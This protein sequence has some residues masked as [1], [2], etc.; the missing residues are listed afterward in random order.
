MAGRSADGAVLG[1]DLS[2]FKEVTFEYGQVHASGGLLKKALP[3][4]TK[5]VGGGFAQQIFVNLDLD[6][7]WLV[8][9]ATGQ[10][11][12]NG[13]L[14]GSTSLLDELHKYVEKACDGEL[15]A[16]GMSTQSQPRM[17]MRTFAQNNDGRAAFM[18][19]VL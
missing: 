3:M 17:L 4:T 11:R 6:Q 9:A 5:A 13:A 16:A 15:T 2:R 1:V 18:P 7:T 8:Q 12:V 10:G 19:I 14:F